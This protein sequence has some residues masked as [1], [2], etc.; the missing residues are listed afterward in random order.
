MKEKNETIKMLVNTDNFEEE[1]DRETDLET[2]VNYK[3]DLVD[4]PPH[5]NHSEYETIDIIDA[6]GLDFYCGNAVK[7]VSR[8]KHKGQPAKDIEKAI[9][10]LKKYLEKIQ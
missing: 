5:Y 7:Y 6:W 2:L 4:H 9:W 3:L 1:P 8:H 10:Y